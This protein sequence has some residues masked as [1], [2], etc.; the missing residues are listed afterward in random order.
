MSDLNDYLYY[1]DR[2][3]A[4]AYE[5]ADDIE[6][7]YKGIEA[8]HLYQNGCYRGWFTLQEAIDF[9]TSNSIHDEWTINDEEE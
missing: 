1:L 5:I 3:E 7:L 9:A 6:H 8:A 4:H 2:A